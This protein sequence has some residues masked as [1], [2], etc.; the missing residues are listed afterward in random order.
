MN[1]KTIDDITNVFYI[2]LD[3]RPDRKNHIEAQLKQVGFSKY[4][5]FNAIKLPN[6]NGRIG[7]IMS[8]IR[9]LE[10]AKERNYSHILIC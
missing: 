3:S 10:I 2:N 1:I 5:R 9:C 6:G 7:C 4:E 8:H